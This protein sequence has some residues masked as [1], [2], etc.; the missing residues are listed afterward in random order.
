MLTGTLAKSSTLLIVLGFLS[1]VYVSIGTPTTPEEIQVAETGGGTSLLTVISAALSAAGVVLGLIFKLFKYMIEKQH[2]M[3]KQQQ[4]FDQK[5]QE[6]LTE[7][8]KD[9]LK[10]KKR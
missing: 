5:N 10:K 3:N 7:I 9:L 4:E 8:I 2:E 6:D 1:A